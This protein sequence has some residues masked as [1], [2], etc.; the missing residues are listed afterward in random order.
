MSLYIPKA[1]VNASAN[2]KERQERLDKEKAA[3]QAANEQ[4]KVT[5]RI[6]M[7]EEVAGAGRCPECKK[8][9]VEAYLNDV[10]TLV[11]HEHRIAIPYKDEE[12]IDDTEWKDGNDAVS[13]A[14]S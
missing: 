5:A 9:M 2:S 10:P 8:P 6:D 7:S 13:D 4:K 14:F 3:V 1:F 12:Q 11:C